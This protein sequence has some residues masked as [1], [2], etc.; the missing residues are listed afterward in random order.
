[1]ASLKDVAR[2][3]GV[4]P[5]TVSKVLSGRYSVSA[6]CAARVMAAVRELDYKPNL[7][8]RG[9]RSNRSTTVL[10]VYSTFVPGIMMGVH[11]AAHE[12]GYEVVSLYMDTVD[13]EYFMKYLEN[14]LAGSVIFVNYRFD[15][16]KLGK[17]SRK[18]PMVQCSEYVKMSSSS[19]VSVDNG[20]AMY[21][22]TE[23]LILAGRRRFAFINTVAPGGHLPF[24]AEERERGFLRALEAH[25]IPYDPALSA[26][27]DAEADY[28]GMVQLA[29][30]YAAMKDSER[31]DAILC[32]RDILGAAFVN[33]LVRAGVKVPGQVAV[34]G[35]DNTTAAEL[36]TPQLTTVEQPFFEMG[37]EAMRLIVSMLNGDLAVN[38]RILLEHRLVFRESA[39]QA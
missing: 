26:R 6:E 33:T 34:T 32:I 9:L 7:L 18:Y 30:R 35:F 17:L 39:L 31:P 21:D 2:H 27:C 25:G 15:T 38:R 19:Q 11:S 28:E 10:M 13:D 5:S 20:Q 1:M 22:L 14:G 36:C 4:A 37:A 29:Q 24:F 12:L 23:Q 3:A 16:E 8:G